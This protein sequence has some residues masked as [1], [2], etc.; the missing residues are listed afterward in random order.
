MHTLHATIDPIEAWV[1]CPEINWGKP[2]AITIIGVSCYKGERL[3]FWIEGV[4]EKWLYCYIP[5]DYLS[6]T[7]FFTKQKEPLCKSYSFI[8][9][10]P[11]KK[12]ISSDKE[13]LFMIDFLDENE[14]FW[15]VLDKGSL[16]VESHRDF[17]K[18]SIKLLKMRDVWK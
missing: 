9:T 18:P 5:S 1:K 2:T 10:P 4:E 6:T 8:I 13:A 17:V 14:I 7:N 3:T 15:V 16:K 12:Q 11:I